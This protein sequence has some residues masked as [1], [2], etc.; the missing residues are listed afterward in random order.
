[1]PIV[2][3]FIA[4]CSER[5]T[6]RWSSSDDTTRIGTLPWPKTVFVS[7]YCTGEARICCSTTAVFL[8]R[9]PLG[10]PCAEAP[11][12]GLP[13]NGVSETVE[14]CL[15]LFRWDRDGNLK[16]LEVEVDRLHVSARLLGELGE[17]VVACHFKRRLEM[18]EPKQPGRLARPLSPSLNLLSSEL[19]HVRIVARPAGPQIDDAREVMRVVAINGLCLVQQFIDPARLEIRRQPHQR[20]NETQGDAGFWR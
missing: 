3:C 7:K 17:P 14:R 8:S 9:L 5:A 19:P 16:R 20:L 2:R 6:A 12:R 1:M 4:W 10:G 15:D 11:E 18:E 13:I